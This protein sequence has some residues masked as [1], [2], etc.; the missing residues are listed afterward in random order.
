MKGINEEN[1]YVKAKKRVEKLKGFY[2]NLAAYVTIIPTMVLVNYMTS[3]SFQWFW[4]PM[5]G[6]GL[7]LSI[8]ALTVFGQ[9]KILG[10]NWEERKIKEIIEK[11]RKAYKDGKL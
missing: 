3:W 5:L 11:E 9:D 8:H 6:W 1:A 7:G 4:I 2:G 10:A